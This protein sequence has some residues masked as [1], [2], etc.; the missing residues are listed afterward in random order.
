MDD[1]YS[2]H[3]GYSSFGGYSSAGFRSSAY[4]TSTGARK[5]TSPASSPRAKRGYYGDHKHARQYLKNTQR[6]HTTYTP[7]SLV[8]HVG[9]ILY[10]IIILLCTPSPFQVVSFTHLVYLTDTTFHVISLAWHLL[11]FPKL[12][13]ITVIY[14]TWVVWIGWGLAIWLSDP[15]MRLHQQEQRAAF[16]I[17]YDPLDPASTPDLDEHMRNMLPLAPF[18]K[19]YNGLYVLYMP[20]VSFLGLLLFRRNLWGLISWEHLTRMD[21]IGQ[22]K[23]YRVWCL[24]GVGAG[25]AL[26]WRICRWWFHVPYMPLDDPSFCQYAAAKP[27]LEASLAAHSAFGPAQYRTDVVEFQF[28][29]MLVSNLVMGVIMMCW[30]SFWTFQYQGVV[31]REDLKEGWAVWRTTSGSVTTGL[32]TDGHTIRKS[33]RDWRHASHMDAMAERLERQQQQQQRQQQ[34]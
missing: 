20:V 9:L 27:C 24:S 13:R 17:D 10:R 2:S 12:E 21:Q 18:L 30:W 28:W 23:Y 19:K 22:L 15:D 11:R 14:G 7:Y 25:W 5:R 3:G 33:V 34:Q 4:S 29:P 6:I 16:G 1:G 32:V 31:W 8:F 26:A